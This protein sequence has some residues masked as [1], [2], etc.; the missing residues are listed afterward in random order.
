M[1]SH[2]LLAQACVCGLCK[3]SQLFAPRAALTYAYVRNAAQVCG[4]TRRSSTYRIL[5]V[6][7]PQD[8]AH[9]SVS[10]CYGC[11]AHARERGPIQ[12]YREPVCCAPRAASYLLRAS[13][14]A[15]CTSCRVVQAA[16]SMRWV[17]FVRSTTSTCA[18]GHT[19]IRLG[20][21]MRIP[22]CTCTSEYH[23]R[24]GDASAPHI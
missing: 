20:M 6:R 4:Q 14:L 3:P 11:D 7:Q 15:S 24:I 22:T 13:R 19:R 12:S 17:C 23:M 2:R 1:R 16:C 9:H 8:D 18:Y 5:H 21:R 10:M